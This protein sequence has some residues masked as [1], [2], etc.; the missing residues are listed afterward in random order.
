M[1]DVAEV[2]WSSDG[3]R[4]EGGLNNSALLATQGRL[5]PDKGA[6]TASDLRFSPLAA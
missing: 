3:I 1:G 4:M 5:T 2:S 6:E